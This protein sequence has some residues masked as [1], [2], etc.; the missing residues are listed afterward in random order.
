VTEIVAD[1]ALLIVDQ[2]LT[3]NR[4]IPKFAMEEL[5]D[6]MAVAAAKDGF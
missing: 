6:V 2:A 4:P 5:E 1:L 3:Q